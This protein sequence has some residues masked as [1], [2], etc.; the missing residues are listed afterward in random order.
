MKRF[1]FLYEKVVSVDNCRLAIL[2]A[3]QN[4]RKRKMVKDVCDNLEDYA[5]DLSERLS[6]MDFLSPYKTRFIKD[7]LSGK[8]RELQIPAFYP[9]QCAHHAI[10]QVLKPIIERS[11]YHWSCA[12]IPK[13]GIDHASKGVERA[14]VRDR[15]HAKYCVKMD[16]SKFYPSIPHGKLKARLREKIK[17]EKFL[18][19][20]FKVIDS[21]DNRD[22]NHQPDNENYQVKRTVNLIEAQ[23]EP[24]PQKEYV[25]QHG[26]GEANPVALLHYLSLPSLAPDKTSSISLSRS[27][28]M[29]RRHSKTTAP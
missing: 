16:I 4:K 2:N 21:H 14:T 29:R 24:Q 18:Q 13:R 15:K 26:N 6:R 10:M 19:I 1:G 17:D 7:G 11:S 27:A 12:N 25:D 23:E 28:V 8:E 20:I 9:D 5:K 3:S 22:D